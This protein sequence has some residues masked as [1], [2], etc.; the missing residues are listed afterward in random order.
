MYQ[1]K[2]AAKARTGKGMRL[3]KNIDRI[4]ESC[5][6]FLAKENDEM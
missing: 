1:I 6:R 3:Y 2:R 5:L 4:P